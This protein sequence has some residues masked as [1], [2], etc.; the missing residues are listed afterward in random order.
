M[1]LIS[2]AAYLFL[3]LTPLGCKDMAKQKKVLFGV[4]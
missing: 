2:V 3:D 1:G 4:T